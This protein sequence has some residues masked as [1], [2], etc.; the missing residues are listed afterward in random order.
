MVFA[1][2]IILTLVVLLVNAAAISD[3]ELVGR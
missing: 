1:V 3:H 2:E